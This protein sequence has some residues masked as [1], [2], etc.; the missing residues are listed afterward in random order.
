MKRMKRSYLVGLVVL[1]GVIVLHM[2]LC[3]VGGRSQ[4]SGGSIYH[5]VI[6]VLDAETRK[7]VEGAEV[8]LDS[9]QVATVTDE[10]GTAQVTIRGGFSRVSHGLYNRAVATRREQTVHVTKPGYTTTMI[11]IPADRD[12]WFSILGFR[13]GRRDRTIRKS[14]VLRKE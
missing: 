9:Q 10:D 7:P 8:T 6:H 3:I 5:A 14:C 13:I 4:A 1:V 11:K 2:I 12:T